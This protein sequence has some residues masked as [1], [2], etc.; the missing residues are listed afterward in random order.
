MQRQLSRCGLLV[1][2]Q[3]E[4]GEV[5]AF[6]KLMV[7]S[8]ARSRAAQSARTLEKLPTE[9][10]STPREESEDQYTFATSRSAMHK[11]KLN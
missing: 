2:H 5:P 3:S 8:S 1:R 6:G 4:P 9:E 10:F 11:L 7:G